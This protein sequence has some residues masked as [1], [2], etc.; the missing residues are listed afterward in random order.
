MAALNFPSSPSVDDEYSANGYTWVWDGV[1]WR[2]KGSNLGALAALDVVDTDQLA[3]KSVTS[4][5]LADTID[6]GSIV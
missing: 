3:D 6:F 2:A 1:S 5:K 4:P